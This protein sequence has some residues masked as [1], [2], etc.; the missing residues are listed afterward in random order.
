LNDVCDALRLRRTELA[1]VRGAQP[2]AKNTLSHAN[3]VRDH[4]LAEVGR[5]GSGF[6]V[7]RQAQLLAERGVGLS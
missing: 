6:V 4:R 2:P 5:I 1:T 7:C 3:K